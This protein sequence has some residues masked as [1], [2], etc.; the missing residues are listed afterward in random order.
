MEQKA[1]RLHGGSTTTCVVDRWNA[2]LMTRCLRTY[3]VDFATHARCN[4]LRAS[5]FPVFYGA[6]KT[7]GKFLVLSD[8]CNSAQA[9]RVHPIRAETLFTNIACLPFQIFIPYAPISRSAGYGVSRPKNCRRCR[10][11]L[12]EKRGIRVSA[13]T[14]QSGPV[15][16]FRAQT[17]QCKKTVKGPFKRSE[18]VQDIFEKFKRQVVGVESIHSGNQHTNH[19]GDTT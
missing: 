12:R 4:V 13:A 7:S 3:R 19:P 16:E 6:R 15:G 10:I 5:S 18:P 1:M 2:A 11:K 9:L 17:T 8:S 14:M